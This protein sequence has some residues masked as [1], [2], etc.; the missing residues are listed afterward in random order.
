VPLG[1]SV[2][3]DAPAET[4][5]SQSRNLFAPRSRP[6]A[7]PRERSPRCEARTPICT[8]S[9]PAGAAHVIPLPQAAARIRTWRVR[10]R[11]RGAGTPD[12]EVP[13]NARGIVQHRG[14]A[15][16]GALGR[17]VPE[18]RA[19]ALLSTAHHRRSGAQRAT[20]PAR[21]AASARFD[22]DGPLP[23]RSPRPPAPARPSAPPARVERT[24]SSGDRWKAGKGARLSVALRRPA[25]FVAHDCEIARPTYAA[26][27][28][29]P[30]RRRSLSSR[31][32][33]R[34]L[35]RRHSFLGPRS[36]TREV[37]AD[38]A[39]R[40]PLAAAPA[41]GHCDAARTA[42]HETFPQKTRDK[43]GHL[44]GGFGR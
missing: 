22:G 7:G 1:K 39:G 41:A 20:A 35:S 32:R 33:S 29:R 2:G 18:M 4:G 8:L 3:W 40:E 12:A 37:R 21:S 26:N 14:Q 25:Q 6:A 44:K 10:L 30:S 23:P 28:S 17:L 9:L 27:C 11:Q 36:T 13:G 24:A 42:V 31:A 34:A 43:K 16:A 5:W 19:R 15:D 38:L